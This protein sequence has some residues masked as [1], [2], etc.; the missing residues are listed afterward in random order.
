MYTLYGHEGA[1]MA[2]QFS[3]SGDYFASA[4]QD[5]V[6]MVW[7]SNLNQFEQ[8]LIDDQGGQTIINL[9]DKS[10]KENKNPTSG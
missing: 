6:V 3:P 7:K 4:G 8:E 9:S 1:A 2:T 5:S 10:T